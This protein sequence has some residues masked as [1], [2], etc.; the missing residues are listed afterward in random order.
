MKPRD[1]KGRFSRNQNSNCITLI[2]PSIKTVLFLICLLLILFPWII[3]IS[4]IHFFQKIEDILD[5]PLKEGNE[6][7]PD[8]GKKED[9]FIDYMN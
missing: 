3:V 5:M 7:A 9:Y 8:N 6:E 2:M 4:K 1:F